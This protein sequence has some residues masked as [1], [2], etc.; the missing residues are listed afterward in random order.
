MGA[1]GFDPH[2]VLHHCLVVSGS[3]ANQDT[4]AALARGLEYGEFED[5]DS[6]RSGGVDE[7]RTLQ[8]HRVANWQARDFCPQGQAQSLAS[9]DRVVERVR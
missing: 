8:D 7:D 5:Y 1:I 3:L 6:S 2:E 9:F 4:F